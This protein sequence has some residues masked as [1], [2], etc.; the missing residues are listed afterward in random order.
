MARDRS[1]LPSTPLLTVKLPS[2]RP[3]EA[4]LAGSLP[5]IQN[6]PVPSPRPSESRAG[7]NTAALMPRAVTTPSTFQV[8]PQRTW[9]VPETLPFSA[10]PRR[11]V[12]AAARERALH[13]ELV[14]RKRRRDG[15]R[16]AG[17]AHLELEL[18]AL[19]RKVGHQ[20]LG[21]GQRSHARHARR[22]EHHVD[23]ERRKR[24][25]SLQLQLLRHD[26][27]E[28]E[29]LPVRPGKQGLAE[30]VLRHGGAL[31]LDAL[32]DLFFVEQRVERRKGSGF[33]DSDALADANVLE[34]VMHSP[35]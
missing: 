18:G 5:V 13:A 17:G 26:A 33:G 30:H 32:E 22:V 7:A 9:A 34:L 4:S 1:K 15:Q 8:P 35:P 20:V 12:H 25:R 21:S 2:R 10:A 23:I 24:Q 28:R 11:D 3:P 19:G 31:Q 27:A 16:K 14:E 6:L 29:V